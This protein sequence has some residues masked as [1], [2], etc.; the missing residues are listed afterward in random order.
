VVERLRDAG[1]DVL[2]VDYSPQSGEVNAVKAIVP[3]LEVE[4]MSYGRIG[5]RNLRRLLDRDSDLVVT[6]DAGG[7]AARR[8]LLTPEMEAELGP[9]W[10]DFEAV[11]RAVA[12]L[13]PLYREPGRHVAA[14]AAEGQAFG[15]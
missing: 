9:A 2:Y 5:P 7:P 15:R 6:G 1:L 13:Y 14:L 3:G 10:L 11:E 12:D 8:I 4:T